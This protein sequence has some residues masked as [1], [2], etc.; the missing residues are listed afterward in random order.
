MSKSQNLNELRKMIGPWKAQVGLQAIKAGQRVILAGLRRRCPVGDTGALKRSIHAT[1]I[2]SG[3]SSMGGAVV[4]GTGYSYAVEFGPHPHPFVMK[5]KE[6]DG[7]NAEQA[8]AAVIKR[9]T[10]K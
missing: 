10:R 1:A 4:V 7:P 3:R 2:R 8:M 5:T 9:N 6:E